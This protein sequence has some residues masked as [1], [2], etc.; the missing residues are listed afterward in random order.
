[1]EQEVEG[2]DGQSDALTFGHTISISN[3][4]VRLRLVLERHPGA[5]VLWSGNTGKVSYSE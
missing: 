4:P 2:R 3:R 1:M 5:G